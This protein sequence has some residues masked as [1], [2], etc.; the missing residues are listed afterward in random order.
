MFTAD[1]NIFESIDISLTLI[2]VVIIYAARF[3]VTSTY[4]QVF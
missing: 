3:N 2:I 4:L 1:I